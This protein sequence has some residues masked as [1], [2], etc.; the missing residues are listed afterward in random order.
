[1][2]NISFISG[3][4]EYKW[5]GG[6]GAVL[7]SRESGIKKGDV[8]VIEDELFYAFSVDKYDVSWSMPHIS[9]EMINNFKRKIFQL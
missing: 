8:R 4:I 5:Y 9:S 7:Q 3:G 6:F 1:M 2:S